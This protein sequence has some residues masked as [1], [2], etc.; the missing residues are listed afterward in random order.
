M[1]SNRLHVCLFCV[2]DVGCA[3]A[4]QCSV[5]TSWP[6]VAFGSIPCSY[7]S[8]PGKTTCV[9][10]HFKSP[11]R[12]E[13]PGDELSKKVHTK[14]SWKSIIQ[15]SFCA[16]YNHRRAPSMWRAVPADSV[17]GTFLSPVAECTTSNNAST[18]SVTSTKDE[19]FQ[20]LHNAHGAFVRY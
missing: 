15:K 4:S 1:A 5:L 10:S 18:R 12:S 6:I 7:A 8:L 13:L 2:W 3:T 11:C 9:F 14:I 19:L 20:T 16:L 17:L